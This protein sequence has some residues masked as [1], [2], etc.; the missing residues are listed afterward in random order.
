MR[1]KKPADVE[2]VLLRQPLRQVGRYGKMSA[3]VW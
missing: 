2:V 3:V 1:K